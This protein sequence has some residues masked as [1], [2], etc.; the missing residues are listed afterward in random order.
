MAVG[1]EGLVVK[2]PQGCLERRAEARK[3]RLDFRPLL[4]GPQGRGVGIVVGL[5]LAGGVGSGGRDLRAGQEGRDVL[6]VAPTDRILSGRRGEAAQEREVT[7]PASTLTP[8]KRAELIS[9][10]LIVNPH[11]TLRLSLTLS[12]SWSR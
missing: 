3:D 7:P 12:P 11:P 1:V 8:R 5:G 2:A 10:C 9:L 4:E 6:H